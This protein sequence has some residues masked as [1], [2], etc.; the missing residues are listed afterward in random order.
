[1]HA[2]GLSFCLGSHTLTVPKMMK[3]D[4]NINKQATEFTH[5]DYAYVPSR[6]PVTISGAPHV[7]DAPPIASIELIIPL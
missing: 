6:P 2:T 4:K 1:M 3:V 7:T 5:N